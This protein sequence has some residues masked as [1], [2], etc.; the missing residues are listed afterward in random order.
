MSGL[1]IGGGVM[2]VLVEFQKRGLF[3]P[4]KGYINGGVLSPHFFTHDR[5]IWIFSLCILY[6]EL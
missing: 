5:P 6:L 4:I 3:I 1:I 2:G